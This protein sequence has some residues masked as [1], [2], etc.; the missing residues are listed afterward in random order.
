MTTASHDSTPTSANQHPATPP[1]WPEPARYLGIALLVIGLFIGMVMFTPIYPTILVGLISAILLD[2]PADAIARR[3]GGRYGLITG[4][5]YLLV[6]VLVVVFVLQGVDWLRNQVATLRQTLDMPGVL[7][8]PPST[9]N[10]AVEA[11]IGAVQGSGHLLQSAFRG[12]ATLVLDLFAA[13]AN[14][15]V[16]LVSVLGMGLLL[17]LFVQLD[18]NRAN[19]VLARFVA[20]R[21]GR[22]TALMLDSLDVIW[23]RFL[24]ANVAYGLVLG[25]ASYIQ[26]LLMGVPFALI[27]AVLTGIISLIPSFG[28]FISNIVVFVPNLVLGSTSP[29][30]ADMPSWTF[31][32][33]VFL[34]NIPITQAAYYFFLLPAM[35]RAV[36]LPMAMVSIGV[37]LAFAFNSVMLAFLI[38]PILGTLRIFGA[39]VLAKAL[40]RDPFPGQAAP[41]APGRPGFFG[42]LY[43]SRWQPPRS[44]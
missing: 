4:L 30:F 16:G 25:I 39:Y 22:E 43:W 33:L 34:I 32:S 44:E 42:Q 24:L 35:S 36:Q 28:G 7:D 26:Y 19:G 38:V 2:I 18:L 3:A 31:A 23:G 27:L 8:Q 29:F 12:I 11:Q 17:G 5:L 6:V 21:S 13:I 40:C 37:L 41:E 20:A 15:V 9:R 1:Q 10:P 14:N